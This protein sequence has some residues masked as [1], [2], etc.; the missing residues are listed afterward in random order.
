MDGENDHRPQ[1]RIHPSRGLVKRQSSYSFHYNSQNA[2][3]ASAAASR[4]AVA[5]DNA[6]KLSKIAAGSGEQSA[7]L[8]RRRFSAVIMQEE[9]QKQPGLIKDT[10]TGI[11]RASMRRSHSL[12]LF[13]AKYFQGLTQEGKTGLKMIDG[14]TWR[15]NIDFAIIQRCQRP[16]Y[17]TQ[18]RLYHQYRQWRN[19]DFTPGTAIA[20]A[21][22]MT[23]IAKRLSDVR[24]VTPQLRASFQFLEPILRTSN[25]QRPSL[26][27]MKFQLVNERTD[28]LDPKSRAFIRRIKELGKVWGIGMLAV[29]LYHVTITPLKLCFATDLTELPQST[30]RTWA[31]FEVFMDILCVMDVSYRIRYAS[32][33]VHSMGTNL[34]S[35]TQ[36][37]F[38]RVFLYNPALRA[39]ILAMIPL[40]L[41]L[42]VSE[43]RVPLAYA[44]SIAETA[45]C[46]WW[47]SRWFLRMNRFLLVQRIEPL[48]EKL[49]QYLVYDRKVPVSD[50]ALYFVRG[51]AS[52]LA[53]G[54]ILAC[55]WFVTSERAF[56]HYGTSWL[57]TSGM[58]TYVPTVEDA[59]RMLTE[60]S[61]TFYLGSVS[62][63]RKYLRSLLFSMECISTLFYGD[64][65]SMNPLELVAEIV[66]TLWS[67][68]IYGALVGAQ[69]ELLNAQARR[70]AAFEQNL[71]E[72]QHYL[73]QNEVPKKLKRQIKSYYA[74]VWRRRKGENEF[75]AVTSV[76]RLLYEDVVLATLRGFATRVVAFRTLDEH[77]LRGLL[78]CLKYVVCS[79][80]EEVT[81]K[82]DVDHS[83]YFIANG[84]VLVKLDAAESIRERGD[85]FGELALLYGISRLETCVA[86][87]LTELYRL[88]Q[89]PY[90]ELLQ[91]FPEYRERNKLDWTS[92]NAP[93]P[94]RTM[95]EAVVRN[96][97]SGSTRKSTTRVSRFDTPLVPALNADDVVANAERINAD[98]PY[99]HIYKFMM[100]LLAHL[101]RVDPLEVRDLVLKGRAGARK[102]LKA[103]LGL[104]TSREELAH[105]APACWYR[106]G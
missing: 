99:S 62:L 87:T 92:C 14:E 80:G 47:T 20:Q 39:D 65:L 77:F 37:G 83:M 5:L 67:I 68:Y 23:N 33:P 101:H 57:S 106:T 12:P 56:H 53:M 4:R 49:F 71:G 51:L 103:L 104:A 45:H 74:R 78:V 95:L 15:G 34:V 79:E 24:P 48:S 25:V 28:I 44:P 89:Q 22:S 2:S 8:R 52:Y 26:M 82:G 3:E 9:I 81:M 60:Q 40:E 98:V 21:P 19:P 54:H 38:R 31:G 84:R 16:Q 86:L 42:F 64:I 50:A 32:L 7:S 73:V 11:T 61:T 100:D 88:D 63:S 27:G 46:S 6:A 17:A 76:S 102:Q 29:A 93:A 10:K 35:S 97:Q 105:A 58:L 1:V 55:I 69:G 94:D 91:N 96:F 18:L 72:L 59:G 66:I 36:G 41:L 30:L 13:E 70:E 43:V 90:E 85:H 75:A